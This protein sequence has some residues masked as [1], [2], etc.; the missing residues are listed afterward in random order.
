MRPR[1]PGNEDALGQAV[2]LPRNSDAE[3]WSQSICIAP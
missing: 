2:D 1:G 3:A